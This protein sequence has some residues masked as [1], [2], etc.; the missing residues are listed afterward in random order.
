MRRGGDTFAMS[1]VCLQSQELGHWADIR[2]AVGIGDDLVASRPHGGG[3][4]RFLLVELGGSRQRRKGACEQFSRAWIDREQPQ[5][6]T[7]IV[8]TLVGTDSLGN[9]AG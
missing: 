6:R 7:R 1:Q 9:E 5:R 2:P 3:F 8:C 4:G